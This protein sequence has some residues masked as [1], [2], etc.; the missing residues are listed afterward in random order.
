M[1]NFMDCFFKINIYTFDSFKNI[2]ANVITFLY[3]N[4][5][6]MLFLIEKEK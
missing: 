1:T 5:R 3:S 6:I 4:K 2:T